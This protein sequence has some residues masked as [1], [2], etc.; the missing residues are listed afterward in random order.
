MTDNIINRWS[1]VNRVNWCPT[2]VHYLHCWIAFEFDIKPESPDGLKLFGQSLSI[3][4]TKV[5][6]M[7][8]ELPV[9]YLKYMVAVGNFIHLILWTLLETWILI[10]L[11]LSLFDQ[12]HYDQWVYVKCSPIVFYIMITK[13]FGFYG[14]LSMNYLYVI[15]HIMLS[16]IYFLAIALSILHLTVFGMFEQTPN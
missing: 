9:S 12:S 5:N 16:I 3:R 7:P 14:A 10:A 8:I 6:E 2:N 11:I 1:L 15:I 4:L 13:F